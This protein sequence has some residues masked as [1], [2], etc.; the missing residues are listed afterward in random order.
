MKGSF[1][2][3]GTGSSMGVPR[4]ACNCEIC[5]SKD[6]HNK[7]LR[8]SGLIQ[9]GDKQILI[10]SG[11]DFRE[12]ALHFNL[13]K[14]DAVIYT[15]THYDHIAGIDELRIYYLLNGKPLPAL[16]S[17]DTMADI[18]SRYGYLFRQN[19]QKNNLTA[20]LEFTILEQE[21]GFIEFLGLPFRYLTVSQGG[22]KVTGYR[23]GDFA[24]ISDIKEYP[25]TI[26]DDLV[27]VNH[28][29]ISALR[30]D[31]SEIHFNINEAIEFAQKVQ[32]E[33]TWLTH[34]SHEL[35]YKRTNA[36]LPK[37][38]QLAYDGLT[39]EFNYYL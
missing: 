8:P 15:H 37:N 18:R 7:R 35:E 22:M 20:Q 6:P 11:P 2:F 29:V 39:L 26:F 24:Y 28:L 30:S 33:H 17:K 1:L 9:V 19:Q 31:P 27:G 21:R 14:I 25:E 10:D 5:T 32:A 3:L 38:I 13:P 23:L 12:Q 16:V 34:L 4:I 36:F